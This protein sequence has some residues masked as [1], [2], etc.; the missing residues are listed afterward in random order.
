MFSP[1]QIFGEEQRIPKKNLDRSACETH[2]TLNGINN[3]PNRL[4]PG[5]LKVETT[6]AKSTALDGGEWLIIQLFREVEYNRA[7]TGD[8]VEVK[9]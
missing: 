7:V 3:I 9:L 5:G 2:L 1:D 4:M 8:G 6:S